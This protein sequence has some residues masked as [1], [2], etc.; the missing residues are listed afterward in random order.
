MKKLGQILVTWI[1]LLNG[2]MLSFFSIKSRTKAG[3]FF[4]YILRIL[5]KK[6]YKITIDNL[7]KAFPDK[8][9]DWIEKIAIESYQNLGITLAELL[10]L[11]YLNRNDLERYVKYDNIELLNEINRRG[12]GL[13]LMSGHFGNW[14][15]LAYTAGIFSDAQVNVIVKPQSNSFMDK[16]LNRYR[17][18]GGNN[19][20][21]MYHAARE[22]LLSIRRKEAVALLADQ[23]ASKT[24]DIYVDFFG[25]PAITFEA[26][27]ALAL[28]FNIPIIMGFSFRQA[29]GTYKV[30]L[31][32]L[33]H[34][35]LD[36]SPDSIKILTQRHVKE[37]EAAIRSKPGHWAWQ[38]RRWKHQPEQAHEK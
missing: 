20:I 6:R 5:S 21:N 33:D 11:K 25:R 14:E 13:I 17:T 10:T 31:T 37:L 34:S 7:E 35:D 27:A 16:H 38:H 8:K 19:I 32:E 26:P 15:F 2:L 23:S 22:I 36:D 24:N 18:S 28:K 4:G 29:D 3:K 9:F 1:M 12:R 30:T